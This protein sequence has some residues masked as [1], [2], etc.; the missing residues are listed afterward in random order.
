LTRLYERIPFERDVHR[1][2]DMIGAIVFRWVDRD[3]VD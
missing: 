1:F 2:G 3:P